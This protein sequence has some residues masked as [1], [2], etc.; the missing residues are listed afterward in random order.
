MG[1]KKDGYEVLDAKAECDREYREK[2][3]RNHRVNGNDES[4]GMFD[5]YSEA[6]PT[7]GGFIPRNNVRERS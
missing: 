2:M 3:K 6:E 1:L 7:P 4:L 5:A